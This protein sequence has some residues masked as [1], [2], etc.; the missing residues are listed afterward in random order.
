MARVLG[1]GGIFFRS[2]NPQQLGAWYEEWLGVPVE[3]P[4]GASLRPDTMPPG[5]FTVWA[6]FEES[7]SYFDPATKQFM[8]NLVVDD[9]DGALDQVQQGGAELVG[10]TEEYEYGRFGWF[11]DPE[12]NKVELWEPPALPDGS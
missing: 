12:G 10:D 6:P 7:T 3:H 5:S 11:I 9:L 8:F 2:A 4:H 1:V